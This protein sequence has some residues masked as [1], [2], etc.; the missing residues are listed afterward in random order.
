MTLTKLEDLP[1]YGTT[2][3]NDPGHAPPSHLLMEPGTYQ[4]KR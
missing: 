4:W 3:C 2:P 1:P